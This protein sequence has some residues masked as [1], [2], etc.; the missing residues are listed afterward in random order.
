[1]CYGAC[2]DVIWDIKVAIMVRYR[3]TNLR[4][5]KTATVSVKEQVSFAVSRW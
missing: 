3:D 5:M 2:N 4:Y 1:V